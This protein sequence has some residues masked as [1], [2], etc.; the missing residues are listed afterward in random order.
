[1]AFT[2]LAPTSDEAIH[3]DPLNKQWLSRQ[4][5]VA[6]AL[7]QLRQHVISNGWQ[8]TSEYPSAAL[9][10]RAREQLDLISKATN[11][12]AKAQPGVHQADVTHTLE[13]LMHTLERGAVAIAIEN[14]GVDPA[15]EQE[16]E[17]SPAAT[18]STI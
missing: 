14:A 1:M 16:L 3:L 9:L 10:T 5:Q 7:T 4:A 11:A 6:T 12:F 13:E 18:F 17:P 8:H 15:T 2:S